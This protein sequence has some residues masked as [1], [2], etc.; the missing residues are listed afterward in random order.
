MVTIK[1]HRHN[2]VSIR[3]TE[4]EYRCIE[5]LMNHSLVNYTDFEIEYSGYEYSEI[6]HLHQRFISVLEP[7]TIFTVEEA[8]ALLCCMLECKYKKFP[9]IDD[10]DRLHIT[11]SI[12]R[13]SIRDNFGFPIKNL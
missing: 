2:S 6:Y 7:E 11:E 12:L 5:V 1:K 3:A 10:K 4:S 8:K 9:D 13:F